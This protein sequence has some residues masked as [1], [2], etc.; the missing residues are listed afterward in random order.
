MN[1]KFE[2]YADG[3]VP[4]IVQDATSRNVLMLGFMNAEAVA[5]TRETSRVTFYSRSRQQLWTKG[6][7]SGNFLELV[8]M[9]ADCDEDTLLIQATP[10]G[11]VCHTGTETC[12]GNVDESH[13]NPIDSL[14]ELEK[15]IDERRSSNTEDSYVA[16]LFKDG[17]N[18]IAQK[19]GEE[20]VE[21]IIEAKDND[22]ERFRS[23]AADL[24]FHYLVLI[25]AKDVS[26]SDVLTTL[27]SRRR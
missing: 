4:A 10:V 11:P 15:T 3:L 2:K 14:L 18:K 5:K 21:L 23:E 9:N 25:R 13:R 24:L 19:V 1:L 12:F 6:E 22:L 7:T 26:I 8:S 17:I 16:S 20:A 27:R